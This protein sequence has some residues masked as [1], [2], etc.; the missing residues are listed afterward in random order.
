MSATTVSFALGSR[1]RVRAAIY[2]VEGR[3]VRTLHRGLLPAGRHDLVWDG[4]DD[5]GK[6]VSPGIYFI[7]VGTG[8][9]EIST[10]VILLR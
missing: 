4:V 6:S 1:D 9:G 2:D 3:V 10:K 7:N 5:G 8:E